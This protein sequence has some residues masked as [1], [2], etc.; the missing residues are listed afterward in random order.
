MGQKKKV[1]IIGG[2]TAGLVIASRLQD[3]FDVTVIEKSKYKKYPFWFRIPLFIGLLFKSK[4]TPYISKRN[5]IL[6][7]GRGIPFFESN[8]LGGA[9]VINGCVH[10]LGNEITLSSM[11]K[12]MGSN[13]EEL[14]D[15]YKR[16]YSMNRKDKL[17]ISLSS[18]SQND[19]DKAFIESLNNRGIPKGDM[20]YSNKESCGPISNTIRKYFRTSVL[21]LFGKKKFQQLLDQ[22]VECFLFN[23]AREVIGVKTSFRDVYSDYIILSAGV[24]GTCTLLLKEQRRLKKSNTFLKNLKI[25]TNI[26]DHTNLRVNVLTNE[27]FGSL[28]E[29]SS[30]FFKKFNLVFKHFSGQPTVMSGTGATSAAHLDL[31]QDGVIDTRIQ[32]LQFSETGRAGSDGKLFSSNRPGFS[33]S[34]TNINPKSKGKIK[35]N[36]D[37]VEVDP[38]YISSEEDIELLKKALIYCIDLLNSEP[39]KHFVYKVEGEEKIIQSPTQYIKDNIFSGYHLIGGSHDLINSDFSLKNATSVYVCDASILSK[40]A[41]SNIHSTV[42]LVADIFSNRFMTSHF[43]SN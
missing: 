38:M 30:S 43:K 10:V 3:H 29:I 25:G 27:K 41:A 19:I 36:G 17:K 24:I 23:D 8:V 32:I 6:P 42:I 21:S 5:H 2:G 34:I 15:S 4:K 35:L 31:D 13:Y 12:K 40:Y 14:L 22:N 11:L 20:I 18:S 9:S 33:I 7:N 26:Q 28:N 16:I 37:N 39:L 1:L